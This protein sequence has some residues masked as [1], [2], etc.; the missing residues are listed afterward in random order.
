MTTE[1]NGI[2]YEFETWFEM[3][4]KKGRFKLIKL[5]KD[6]AFKKQ[7]KELKKVLFTKLE[8]ETAYSKELENLPSSPKGGVCFLV[9]AKFK[10]VE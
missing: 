4:S 9:G 10:I 5:R 3:K 7:E 8:G 1:K 2:G 6:D